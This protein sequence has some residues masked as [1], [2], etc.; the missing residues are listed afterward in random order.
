MITANAIVKKYL[1][2]PYLHKGRTKA[3]LDCW[4]LIK[5]IYSDAGKEVADL[6]DYEA[7]WSRKGQDYFTT[8]RG[9]EWEEVEDEQFLDVV[10]FR[11]SK[12]VVNHA[13]VVLD[14]NRF[15]H[16]C[17]AGVVVSRLGD[18]QWYL[19]TEG[20]YRLKQRL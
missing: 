19:K 16:C 2:I 14:E 12:L 10:L 17:R 4:G 7:N 13:G 15:I 3:G 11:A 1:G 9:Q 8:L 20:F 6:D 18:K 5:L